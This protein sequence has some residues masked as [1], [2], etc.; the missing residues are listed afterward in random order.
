[1][2]Y[3][4]GMPV[5]SIV[6]TKGGVGKSTSALYLATV[7]AQRGHPVT[8]LDADP[9]GTASEWASDAAGGGTPLP[10]PVIPA[11]LP[12]QIP[13]A[14]LV[15]I[16]T[17]PGTAGVIQAA[18]DAADLVVVPT[19][20][21]PLDVRRV[22]PTLEITAHRPT[23]VLLTGVALGTRLAA[24][25]AAL[26]AE[27]EIPVIGTPIVRREAIKHAYGTIPAHK[28]GYDDVFTEIQEALAHV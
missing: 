23:A 4:D 20:V 7:A 12:L 13:E 18:I 14:A 22:W 9:Q 19:G 10:F 21:S 8:L 17:P 6:H 27:E 28:H 24:E 5:I 25:A 1:M 15:I 16:D 3:A 2:T 26:L 11:R